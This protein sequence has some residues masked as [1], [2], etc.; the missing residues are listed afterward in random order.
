[1]SL[2][3]WTDQGELICPYCGHHYRI[4]HTEYFGNYGIEFDDVEF[5]C[6]KCEETY[7]VSRRIQFTY[8]TYK[9]GETE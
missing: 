9:K 7:T 1:M 6:P 4:D 8:E 3:T 2:E 5:E